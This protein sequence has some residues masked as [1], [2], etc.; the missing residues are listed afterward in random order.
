MCNPAISKLLAVFVVVLI[1]RKKIIS[2]FLAGVWS[3]DESGMDCL[4]VV[5][6]AVRDSTWEEPG[7]TNLIFPGEE[8]VFQKMA[9]ASPRPFAGCVKST[10]QK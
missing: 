1:C 2:I 5:E 6:A 8:S 7:L 3:G 9:S 4:I 10:F